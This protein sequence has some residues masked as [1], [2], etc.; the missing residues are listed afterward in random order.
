MPFLDRLIC[1]ARK[2]RSASPVIAALT[3][4]AV[5]PAAALVINPEYDSSITSLSNASQVEAAFNTV[6]ND[7]ASSFNNPVTINVGVSWGSVGGTALPS[8]AVGA[9]SVSLYGYFSYSQIKSYLASFSKNNV[10]D[11]AL[12]TAV[13]NLP[14][15]TPSGVRQYVIPSSETKALGLISATNSALDGSIGF[16]GSSSNYTYNPA[17]G[18]TAGT[19]DFQAVAAH[20]LDEVLGRITGLTSTS[21]SYR[22]VFDLFRYSAAG[23]LDFGYNDSA[24]FAI[25]GGKTRLANFNNSSYG[26]DRSDLLT[27]NTSTDIQDAFVSTG[28]ALNLT[29]SDLTGLDVLG[30]GGSN[31]GDTSVSS[32]TT[33]AFYLID[34]TPV[35]EPAS[36]VLLATGCA[37]VAGLGN[38]R[39]RRVR[40][41]SS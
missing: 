41:F 5:H 19:Y 17:G 1:A 35:P 24:Y 6:A 18:I 3:I 29:A 25:D 16:A 15:N 20:E 22:T 31:L 11:T 2:C 40:I 28:Q 10:A 26:G 21:P 27:L 37:V 23:T 34:E 39:R 4:V 38:V 33:V 13:A 9:S 14:K 36:V 32:P 8:N 30:Y 12:T 7:Y